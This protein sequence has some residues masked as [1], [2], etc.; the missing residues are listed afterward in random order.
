MSPSS[1]GQRLA[2]FWILMTIA[3]PPAMAAEAAV[4]PLRPGAEDACPVCGMFVAPHAEWSAQVVFA[5]G[6]AV[7]FDGCKDLFGY[8]LARDRFLP[9]RRAEEI[10]AVFVT[11]YYELEPVAA[12]DAWYVLGS[13]VYGPMGSELVPHGTR[14]EAEEFLR[15]HHGSRIVGFDEVTADLLLAL[16]EKRGG[17]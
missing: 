17:R 10:A 3:Q 5:D 7:F 12:A 2:V 6:S 8:L 15:D 11:S 4:T 13:D 16:R 1:V 14:D 9:D